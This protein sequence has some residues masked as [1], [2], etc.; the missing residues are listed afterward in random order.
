MRQLRVLVA[1]FAFFQCGP[2]VALE[3]DRREA[4]VL[5][6]RVFEGEGYKEVF[7]PSSET[8]MTLM[9][10]HDN[11]VSLVRTLEYYWPLSRQVY[12]DFEAKKE[13]IRGVLTISSGDEV[14]ARIEPEAWAILYPE[15]AVRGNATLLWGADAIDGR[16][17]FEEEERSFNRRLVEAQRA[18]R[19]YE[20]KL[21]ESGAARQP[22]ETAE[23]IDPPPSLPAPSLRLV[24]EPRQ[25]YRINL[26]AGDYRMRFTLDGETVPGSGKRLR[27][28]DAAGSSRIVADIVPEER[29][30]RPIPSNTSASRVYAREGSVFY[31]TLAEASEFLET[32]Y[33]PVVAPQSAPVEGRRMWVRRGQAEQGEL[34]L[35]WGAETGAAVERQQLKVEQTRGSGFGYRVRPAMEGES[36]DLDAFPIAVPADGSAT[37]GLLSATGD[38][39]GFARQIV[40]VRSRNDMAAF[41]LALLPM[42]LFAMIHIGKRTRRHGTQARNV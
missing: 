36:P 26:P 18:H 38:G 21:L 16:R 29:W 22:G 30:T 32:E 15:G 13:E 24:T 20:R 40:V 11:A 27:V 19:D 4:A 41:L 6:A 39:D 3:P 42:V 28:A 9:A 5:H 7:V 2:A 17:E 31:V 23:V 34:R 37:R 14:V 1:V 25:G 33:M 12:V 8:A 10:G 35:D